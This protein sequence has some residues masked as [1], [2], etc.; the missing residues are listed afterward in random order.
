MVMIIILIIIATFG[1]FHL[2]QILVHAASY[3]LIW[4]MMLTLMNLIKLVI[5]IKIETDE[6]I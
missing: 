2:P 6:Y 3:I 5:V 1:R 4:I